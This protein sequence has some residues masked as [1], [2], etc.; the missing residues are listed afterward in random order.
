MTSHSRIQNKSKEISFFASH[1]P[2]DAFDSKTNEM[3]IDIFVATCELNPGDLVLDLGCGSGVFSEILINRG[4]RCVGVDLCRI[5][6]GYARSNGRSAIFVNGD[7][8]ALPL[9]EN[10]ID[11]ILLVGLI[12]HFPDPNLCIKEIAR[13]L[14]IGCSFL[15]LDPNRVNPFMFLYR[16]KSSP[17]YS[18]VGV[19]E[20]ERPVIASAI[21]KDFE[22]AG[23][24]VTTDFLS[25]LK[26]NYV[27]SPLM[28]R[29][30][31]CYNFRGCTR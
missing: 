8:E 5:Q 9:A 10:E 16:D 25:G 20:N 7:A 6:L 23:L 22:A 13:V 3:I 30:L 14:K 11:G 2:Y 21:K 15:A 27:E 31:P 12:H 29:L 19:S 18:S 24:K 1:V 28:R 4:Y 26:Y 17:F